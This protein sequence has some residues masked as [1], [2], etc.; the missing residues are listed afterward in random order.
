[1]LTFERFTVHTARRRDIEAGI[2]LSKRR[3][4]FADND[5][6]STGSDSPEGQSDSDGS[7]DDAGEIDLSDADTVRRELENLRKANAQLKQEAAERRLSNKELS[8]RLDNIEKARRKQLEEQGNYKALAEE[9]E[10]TLTELAPFKERAEALEQRI[11][12]SNEAMIKRIPEDMR[13]VV[14][15]NYPPEQ[16]AEWLESNLSLLT[17]AP[18]PP[19]DGG[20]GGSSGKQITVTDDDRMAA[21]LARR[22]GYVITPEDIAKRRKK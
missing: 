10:R 15:T 12:A 7:G 13:S 5:D 20:A 11:R 9:R 2:N 1:M 17:K 3:V 8:D 18:A 22:N 4:W 16:L 14:P 6:G 21:E 19:L